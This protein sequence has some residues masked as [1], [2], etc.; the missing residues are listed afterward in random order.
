MSRKITERVRRV[1]TIDPNTHNEVII[2]DNYEIGGLYFTEQHHGWGILTEKF[3]GHPRYNN[4]ESSFYSPE[5]VVRLVKIAQ[6]RN[7]PFYRFRTGEGFVAVNP[8]DCIARSSAKPLKRK[9]K[10]KTSVLA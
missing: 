6:Q 10:R 1:A 8:V 9:R 4:G 7:I 3:E 5:I 2:G